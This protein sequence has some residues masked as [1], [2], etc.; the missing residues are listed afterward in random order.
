MR[1]AQKAA[2]VVST[3]AVPSVNLSN[4]IPWRERP[5]VTM[6]AGAEI[7][8]VSPASLYRFAEEGKLKL[9]RLAG[10][11]LIETP[12]L[13][14]LVGAVEPWSPSGRTKGANRRRKELAQ[15]AQSA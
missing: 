9:V 4:S 3:R 1:S 8:G 15:S 5:F 7:V 10:R 11:T 6:Q 2:P 13:I 12:S 14:V